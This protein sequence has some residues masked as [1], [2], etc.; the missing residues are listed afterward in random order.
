MRRQDREINDRDQIDA[1]IRTC[2]VCHLGL[3][4]GPFTF[5]DQM[6]QRTAVVR[7]TLESLTG[8]QRPKA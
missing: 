8:K 4:D 5:G 1:I 7:V 6:V 2:T 3:A